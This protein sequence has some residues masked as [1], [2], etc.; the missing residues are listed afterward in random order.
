ML[1]LLT[2]P[3][4]L[5]ASAKHNEVEVVAVTVVVVVN[6]VVVTVV[7]VTVVVVVVVRVVVELD[8]HTPHV[9][10]HDWLSEGIVEQYF[11]RPRHLMESGTP[12]QVNEQSISVLFI[13]RCG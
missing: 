9:T 2:I 10:G 7:V 11:A 12:L 6:V 8:P 3:G 13:G 1:D 4:A 5:V